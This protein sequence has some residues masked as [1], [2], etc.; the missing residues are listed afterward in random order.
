MPQIQPTEYDIFEV[1]PFKHVRTETKSDTYF[2]NISMK[3]AKVSACEEV[4]IG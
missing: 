4:M 3:V 2:R 1:C